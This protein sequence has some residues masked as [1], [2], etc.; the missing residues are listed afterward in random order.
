MSLC[1]LP[2]ALQLIAL[3]PMGYAKSRHK[4]HGACATLKDNEVAVGFRPD[5]RA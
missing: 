5:M 2:I 3:M 1:G 4:Q